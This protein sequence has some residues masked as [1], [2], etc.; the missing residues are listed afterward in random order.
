MVILALVVFFLLIISSV[1]YYYRKKV[2]DFEDKLMDYEDKNS[3]LLYENSLLQKDKAVLES[4]LDDVK[5]HHQDKIQLLEEAKERLSEQ[6]ETLSQQIFEKKSRSFDEINQKNMNELLRPFREQIDSFSKESKARYEYESKER[7]LLKDEI[8]R[9]KSLNESI[10]KD[11]IN[12]T[13][14]LLG[15]NKTQGNW[16]EVILEKIL[17]DSGLRENHEYVREKSLHN[18]EDKRY[19]PDVIVHLP[20][21]K[22]I[23]IDSKVSLKAYNFYVN[24]E[25]SELKE[26]Y[27][28]EH[29]NSINLHVKSLSSKRYEE[30]VGVKS[31]DFILLF[32]PIEGSFLL[33]LEKD[34]EF[35]SNAYNQNI[36]VVSPST[37]LVTLRTIEHIW[38]SERQELH[39]QE[40]A[41]KAENLYDKFVLFVEDMKKM[42]V[43]I[44]KT[45]EVYDSTMNKLHR[46]K[47]NLVKRSE[48]MRKLGLKPKKLLDEKLVGESNVL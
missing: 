11:A 5:V 20:K 7:Y 12:L 10:S 3:D 21:D 42:G 43:Q 26:K 32:M 44:Q 17:E 35:F 36:I 18:E 13:K 31:L 16:G 23:I 19:R 45:Q 27:L 48:D 46:G 2:L 37:L 24:E 9:L 6:F 38:R 4:K 39:A 1:I 40:I 47:G 41:S 29:L 34:G 22:D 8:G 14:A 28:K 33:A 30:L 25:N 15:E